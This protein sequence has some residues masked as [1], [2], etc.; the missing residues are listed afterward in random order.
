MCNK[1]HMFFLYQ[2]PIS[3]NN[4]VL[5]L[6]ILLILILTECCYSEYYIK[7]VKSDTLPSKSI[8]HVAVTVTSLCS[9]SLR[10]SSTQKKKLSFFSSFPFVFFLY[11]IIVCLLLLEQKALNQL[12]NQGT[13]IFHRLLY[14]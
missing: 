5:P 9:H 6:K 1:K 13:C 10:P 8:Y 7:K 4:N 14:I 3:I 12:I 11:F 2:H